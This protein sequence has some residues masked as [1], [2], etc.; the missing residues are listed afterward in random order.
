MLPDDANVYKL[1][2]PALIKQDPVEAK[3]NVRKRIDFISN[4][5]TRSE[6]QF[7]SM[8]TKM[9]DHQREVQF[10]HLSNFESWV[11]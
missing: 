11:E 10:R 2:G 9:N 7:K 8:E 5:L 3:S 6:N 4:E 1:I